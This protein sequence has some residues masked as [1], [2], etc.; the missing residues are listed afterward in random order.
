MCPDLLP[1]KPC[2]PEVFPPNAQVAQ[3]F[4]EF[5]RGYRVSA[6]AVEVRFVHVDGTRAIHPQSVGI[7][8][9]FGKVIIMVG[10]CVI[11]YK[12]ESNLHIADLDL[13]MSPMRCSFSPLK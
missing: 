12:L 6:E 2:T 4:N 1:Q 9:G 7:S 13:G 5:L 11:A 3:H 8:D 10:I